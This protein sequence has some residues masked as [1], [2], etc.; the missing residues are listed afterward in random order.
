[1]SRVRVWSGKPRQTNPEFPEPERPDPPGFWQHGPRG[2]NR[3]RRSARRIDDAGVQPDRPAGDDR[4]PLGQPGDR[5]SDAIS[6]PSGD[7]SDFIEFELP[8]N[9]NPN[10]NVFVTLDGFVDSQS[11]AVVHAT[12]F[13]DG[14]ET[15]TRVLLNEGE[16]TITVDNTKVQTLRVAFTSVDDVAHLDYTLT[17]VAFR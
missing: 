8:N 3:S 12:L 1:M 13:E 11:D 5:P 16:V 4:R 17:V 10:Q 6:H 7:D 14:V 2:R 9:S 15:N